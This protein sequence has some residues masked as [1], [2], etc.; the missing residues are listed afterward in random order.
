MAPP[1][2]TSS[3]NNDNNSSLSRVKQEQQNEYKTF[4]GFVSE[5]SSLLVVVGFTMVCIVLTFTMAHLFRASEKN[6]EISRKNARLEK[7][8]E[9]IRNEIAVEQ[10]DEQQVQIVENG[11]S[12]IGSRLKKKYEVNWRSIVFKRLLGSGSFGDCYLGIF[13]DRKVAVKKMRLGMVDEAG[14]KAFVKEVEMLSMLEHKNL[15]AFL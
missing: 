1:N 2:A 9:R 13:F 10:F 12:E 7:E 11:R 3:G 15:V 4:V 6:R 14:F 5:N 8:N